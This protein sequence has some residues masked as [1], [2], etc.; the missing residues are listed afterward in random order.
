LPGKRDE[1]GEEF[2]PP[3]SYDVR[4]FTGASA[5]RRL[6]DGTAT[7]PEP[8]GSPR[9]MYW[10]TGAPPLRLQSFGQASYRVWG[11]VVKKTP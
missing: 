8:V 6:L 7:P 9:V 11:D 10:Q 5:R 1:R 4:E 3:A 2:A